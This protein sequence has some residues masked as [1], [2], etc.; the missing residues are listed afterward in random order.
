MNWCRKIE[1]LTTID[2][3]IKNSISDVVGMGIAT[4]REVGLGVA[5]ERQ[6]WISKDVVAA[7]ERK[8]WITKVYY[9]SILLP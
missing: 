1:C 6:K 2:A 4:E 5:K 9:Y 7:K 8:K 3:P